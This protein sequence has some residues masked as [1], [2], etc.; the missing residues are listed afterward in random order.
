M[1]LSQMDNGPIEAEIFIATE[2]YMCVIIDKIWVHFDRHFLLNF[3][4]QVS[5]DFG[6]SLLIAP[7]IWGTEFF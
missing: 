5:L 7:E 1:P 3:P 4:V 2:D 6:K